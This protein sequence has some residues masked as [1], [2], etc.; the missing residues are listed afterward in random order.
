MPSKYIQTL[1]ATFSVKSAN[2]RYCNA[3]SEDLSTHCESTPCSKCP[4]NT[5][6]NLDKAVTVLKESSNE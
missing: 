3:H 5:K 1:I 4:F 2:T 6:E